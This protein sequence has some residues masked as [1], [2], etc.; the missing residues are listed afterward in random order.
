MANGSLY[1]TLREQIV[2][3]IR[4][5]VLTGRIA[6][7]DSLREQALAER[8]GVSRGPIRDALLQ[9]TQEGLLVSRPNCGVKVG[10][11]PSAAI[12]TLIV[13]MRRKTEA[14]ALRRVFGELEDDDLA[15]LDAILARL[16]AACEADDM[17]SV[18][19]HDMAF[20]RWFVERTGD[21]D[22]LAV[23]LPVITRMRLRYTRHRNLL[24]SYREHAA[25]VEAIRRGDRQA[26]VKALVTN[27]QQ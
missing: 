19:Q 2:E 3:Q 26:A 4:S 23:W 1:R 18:V 6:E 10:P 22:L 20:H 25:V 13:D 21:A 15:Q 24:E 12:Q 9:L 11:A 17:A 8:F 14:H 16:R 5:D 7:G 27:I